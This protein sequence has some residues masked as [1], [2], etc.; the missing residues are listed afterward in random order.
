MSLILP[1]RRDSHLLDK[2]ERACKRDASVKPGNAFDRILQRAA[3]SE[4]RAEARREIQEPQQLFLPGFE[5]WLR[6]M[7]NH[8][9][10][11]SLFAPI[12]RGKKKYH[13]QTVLASRGD[14]I[15]TYTG[16][17]LDEV[18]ADAWMQLIYEA[19]DAPLGQA[20]SINRAAFLRAIGKTTSGREYRWMHRTMIEF[21]AATIVIEA[22]KSDGTTRYHIG[23][24]KAFHMLSDFDYDADAEKYTFTIDPR[25]KT[26]FGGNEYAL[27]DWEKR[28]QIRPARDMAKALQRLVATSADQVQHHSLD[29]LR[30]M[31]QYNSPM[32]KFRVALSTAMRELERVGVVAGARIE[33]S[34]KRVE[35][36]TWTKLRR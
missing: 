31:L 32:G 26:L 18:Q 33:L 2:T 27:I 28:L 11:S 29:R 21:T 16:R 23:H 3:E 25:W 15:I 9:A 14:V 17:Q 35:Q 34:T 22:R 7:P 24:T 13:D 8:M 30:D 10:R 1:T 6:A 5:E 4:A 19:K 36:A 20:V 12:A